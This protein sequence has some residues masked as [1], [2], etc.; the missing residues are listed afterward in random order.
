M[1]LETLQ[2]SLDD[3][4]SWRKRELTLAYSLA[5]SESN[6]DNGKYLCRSWVVI[7]YAHCDQYLKESALDYIDFL[8]NSDNF[9]HEN[10][11][12]LIF[13]KGKDFIQASPKNHY[14]YQSLYTFQSK[15]PLDIHKNFFEKNSINY[16]NLRF[17]CNWLLLIDFTHDVFETFLLTLVKHRNEI[18]HGEE[19]YL[20]ISE[21][22]YLHDNT[23]FFLNDFT[24]SLIKNAKNI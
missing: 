19:K 21:C 8:R 24:D 15:P 3:K 5:L 20:D 7:M 22:K 9:N 16:K 6:T 1:N 2:S 12:N 14:T 4:L 18:A 11:I 13:L 10:I 17:I 23:I